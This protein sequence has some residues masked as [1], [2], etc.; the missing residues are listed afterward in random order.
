MS[1][2][3]KQDDSI[4]DYDFKSHNGIIFM[5]MLKRETEASD[6]ETMEIKYY[7]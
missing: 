4:S 6:K 2:C 3:R 7:S 1:T 5:A